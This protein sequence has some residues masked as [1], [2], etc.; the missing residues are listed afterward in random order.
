MG[1]WNLF[2]VSYCVMEDYTFLPVY[3]DRMVAIAFDILSFMGIN[4]HT[5]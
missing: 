2:L 5:N 1:I 4:L 3:N